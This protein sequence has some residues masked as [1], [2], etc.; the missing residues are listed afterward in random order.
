MQS[1][2]RSHQKAKGA[3]RAVDTFAFHP[4]TPTREDFA[5]SVNDQQRIP[6]GDSSSIDWN[7]EA[8]KE[9]VRIQ[10][11]AE[12]SGVRGAAARTWDSA[13]PWLV[14]VATGIATGVLASAMDIVTAWLSDLRFGIC[15]DQWWMSR[16]SCCTGLDGTLS[17]HAYVEGELMPVCCSGRNL[18]RLEN[19]GN[20]R[21]RIRS[22]RAALYHSVQRVYAMCRTSYSAST[23]QRS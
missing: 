20:D 18:Q 7:Y 13:I 11:L 6:Y 4:T 17:C 12:L 9:R 10:S 1:P 22:R 16:A 23:P 15:R 3:P 8:Q 19:L 14:V 2:R 5:S 21:W